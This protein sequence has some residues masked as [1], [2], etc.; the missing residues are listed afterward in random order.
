MVKHIYFF[1]FLYFIQIWL[2]FKFINN[3]FFN[4]WGHYRVKN[5][6]GKNYTNYL[7]N[8]Q[9]FITTFLA[10][11]IKGASEWESSFFTWP[12]CCQHR[13]PAFLDRL[14]FQCVH[15]LKKTNIG[16]NVAQG[17]IFWGHTFFIYFIFSK[18][19]LIHNHFFL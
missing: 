18:N 6:G 4:S 8:T 15:S 2:H 19:N 10:E 12:S 3:A 14:A 17:N 1:I 5:L 13:S 9:I 11:G 16:Q 7:T